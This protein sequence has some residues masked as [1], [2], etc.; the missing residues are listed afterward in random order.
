MN[1][2]RRMAGMGVAAVAA[3]MAVLTASGAGNIQ[4]SGEGVF[5]ADGE[6]TEIPSVFTM[7]LEGD[8]VGCLYT[9][10]YE[11]VQDTPSGVYSER[12][13]ERFIGCLADGTTCGTFDTTYKFTAKYAPDGSQLHG[14]CQHPITFGTGDFAGIK[15]RLD[16][17]DDVQTGIAHYRGHIKLPN[18]AAR[19]DERQEN[20]FASVVSG[21]CK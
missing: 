21:G 17:K 18:A 7:R 3:L 9:H 19:V 10:E 16:F 8:L 13:T 20:G 4:I 14:R 6:C 2:K 12:G 5:D 15:G 1:I 11:V